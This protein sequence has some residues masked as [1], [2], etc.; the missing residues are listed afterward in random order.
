MGAFFMCLFANNVWFFAFLKKFWRTNERI[1]Q[2]SVTDIVAKG[3]VQWP[4]KICDW[5]HVQWL[6]SR[7]PDSQIF[8]TSHGYGMSVNVW[9]VS[10]CT[11]LEYF[12]PTG[13][14][15][16]Y[17]ISA[18]V[19][20]FQTLYRWLVIGVFFQILLKDSISGRLKKCQYLHILYV[21]I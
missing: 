9:D 20:D 13:H 8:N 6:V 21:H 4:S 7:N 11:R 3:L 16:L 5:R 14:Q 2:W 19:R 17:E 15:S 10:H 1:R 12:T 18:T